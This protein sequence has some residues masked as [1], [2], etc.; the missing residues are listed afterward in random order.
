MAN[1]EPTILD[2]ETIL[3]KQKLRAELVAV[4]EWGGS[5]YVRELTSAERDTWEGNLVTLR[6]GSADIDFDNARASLAAATIVNSEGKRLFSEADV[7]EL[8]KLSGAAMNRVYEVATKLSGIREADI[9][10]LAGN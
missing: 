1:Q 2:R 6:G 9:E 8:G 3:G 10:E 7:I 5:V 4:P